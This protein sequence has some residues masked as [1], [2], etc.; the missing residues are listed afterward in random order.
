MFV[1]SLPMLILLDNSTSKVGVLGDSLPILIP[2]D[3]ALLMLI[4]LND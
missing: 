3:E 4:L 2:L 1:A